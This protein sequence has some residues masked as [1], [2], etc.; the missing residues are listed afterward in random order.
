MLICWG[1]N[2]KPDTS[3]AEQ[4]G[5]Q[6]ER[7]REIITLCAWVRVCVRVCLCVCVVRARV[8]VCVCLH[9]NCAIVTAL[10]TSLFS[11][12]FV[13]FVAFNGATLLQADLFVCMFVCMFVLLHAIVQGDMIYGTFSRSVDSEP[14]GP[15][16]P[17]LLHDS[18]Y[19]KE[20]YA[21]LSSFEADFTNKYKVDIYW[22]LCPR[23]ELILF[24][25][26]FTFK[27]WF[28]SRSVTTKWVLY[29]AKRW[30]RTLPQSAGLGLYHKAMA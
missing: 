1:P 29:T 27:C 22:V 8:F 2:S 18:N 21:S 4:G 20:T 7:G 5:A 17:W 19:C 13:L 14:F 26:S 23:P 30:L 3:T 11:F 6:K 25:R 24:S 10:S 9:V 15:G 12:F 16:S 28:L